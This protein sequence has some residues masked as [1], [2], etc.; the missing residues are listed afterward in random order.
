M[1]NIFIMFA[2]SLGVSTAFATKPDAKLTPGELCT[3]ANIDFVEYR[4]PAHIA[5]C[6]RNVSHAMKLQIAQNYGGIPD[7]EWPNYEFDHLIPLNAGGDSSIN[8]LW[9]QPIAEAKDKDHL[10]QQT[11]NGLSAGTLTQAEA[12]QMIWDWVDQH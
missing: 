1:T 4:Y 11:Y 3:P 7:S 2:L 5:Y 8:N 12:V 6:K 9:P 10:E